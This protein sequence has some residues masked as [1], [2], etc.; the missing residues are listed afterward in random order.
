MKAPLAALLALLTGWAAL[1]APAPEPEE[2]RATHLGFPSTRFAPPLTKPEDVRARFRD[3][4]LRPD[5]A[6]V[7]HR[8]GWKGDLD[9]LFR[10]GLT[11]DLVDTE[12]KIGDRMPF[13]STREHGVPVLLRNVVWAG[14]KP[15]GAYAFTFVSKGHRY[16]CVIP[17]PCSN[18]YVE[19]L[20]A[21][22]PELRLVKAEPARA[23]VCDP[24]E[25]RLVVSNTGNLTATKVQVVDNLPAGWK[26]ADN[27]V[28][29]LLNAGDLP[30]GGSRE[31]TYRISAAET[32]IYTNLAQA[33][34]A[35]GV[36]AAATAVTAIGA[37]V[38]A[39]DC[40]APGKM[41]AGR[42]FPVCLTLRNTGD[43][44]EAKTIVTLPIPGDA[45]LTSTTEGG[46]AAD[47]RITWEIGPLAAGASRQLCASFAKIPLGPL[48]FAATAAPS[49]AKPAQTECETK[50]VGVPALLLEVVDKEDP[51]QVGENVT[52][53][54]RV[55]NQGFGQLTHIQ[56]VCR[57]PASQEFVSSTGPSPARVQDDVITME[58]LPT[59]EPKAT[60]T[61]QVIMKAVK[62]DDAR[63][64]VE[65]SADQ[66]EKPIHEDEST[67]QY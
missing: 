52:Y 16:R 33:D 26:T 21:A 67:R 55:M 59:L 53:E 19:D 61:W 50:I 1:A 31:F 46:V 41:V 24:F 45:T 57:R 44:P 49:C 30:P 60:V 27:R 39:L 18:F 64:K 8:W 23:S 3:I 5:F 42:A 51:V 47:G 63:F 29:L 43:A 32:G 22:Q 10:A 13:M 36:T 20:G 65:L 12:I 40:S 56:V 34:C 25:L 11:A 66:Y 48:K 7:L 4:R 15:V 54:I 17:K 2:H 35:E 37:P 58:M 38:L 28:S 14:A 6:M 62:E 9:D